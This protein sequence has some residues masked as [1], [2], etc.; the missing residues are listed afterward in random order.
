MSKIINFIV[1]AIITITFPLWI[2]PVVI[3]IIKIDMEDEING[4]EE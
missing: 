1:I 4:M 3:I 2:V